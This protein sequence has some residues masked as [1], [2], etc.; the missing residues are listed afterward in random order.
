MLIKLLKY[1]IRSTWRH[2]AGAYLAILLG[3]I[4]IPQVFKYVDNVFANVL[5]GF[6][7]TAI[8]TATVAVTI[9]MI[10]KIFNANVFS[11]QGYLTM[12]LPAT[13][14]EIVSSK[15]LVSTMW[16]VLTG[17]VAALGIF[18]FIWGTPVSGDFFSGGRE[19]LAMLEG[20]QVLSA[21]LIVIIIVMSAVKEIAKLFLACSIA[22][23]KP[24]GR[25][26]VLVGILSYFVFSWL[27]ALILKAIAFVAGNIPGVQSYVSQLTLINGFG[28]GVDDFYGVFNSAIGLGILY[29]AIL[30]GVYSIGTIWIL[31]HK[32]DLD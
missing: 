16:V 29:A 26:R 23:L 31:N 20:R 12:T 13:S 24:L 17:I 32:L 8:I 21:V 15:L 4:I 1:D 10:F 22:H 18:I 7:A 28:T 9:I 25:F 2:F 30:V 6:I 19:L 5:A 11:K 27:E 14:T 3:V